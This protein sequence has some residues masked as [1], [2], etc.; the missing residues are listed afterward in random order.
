[1]AGRDSEM[2]KRQESMVLSQYTELYELII[3]K[4]NLLRRIMDLVDFSFV[5]EELREK[6]CPDNGRNAIDPVRL[7]KYLL[8]KSIY[9]LSDQDVVER[10]M[11][12]MSFKYFL[13]MAPEEPVI[14]PSTLTKFRKQR[15]KDVELLDM[16]IMKTMEI[17]L[18]KEVI[19]TRSIIVDATHTRA[20]YALKSPMEILKDQSK[21]LRKS[22]YAVDESMKDKFPEKNTTEELT[23]ELDYCHQLIE[24]IE[25]E[26]AL[27]N[28]PKVKERLNRLKEIVADDAEHLQASEDEDARVGHKSADHSFFG[29]KTH[30]AMTEER[31][32][33]AAVITTGEKS[34]GK[35][36][37]ELIEKSKAAGLKVDTVIGDAAYSEKGN[38]ELTKS[39]NI[40]LVS[41][42]NPSVTQGN[43][44]KE[45]EFE[46]NKDAGMY[47]CKA[48]HLAFR[49]ARQGKKN[50]QKNQVDTYYFDVEKCKVCPFREG[51]YKEGAKTKTY[52]VSVK[53]DIH[54][55]QMAFQETEEFRRKAKER[56]KI[57]AKND[58]LKNR[59]GLKVAEASGLFGME[60]QGATAIFSV[61]L[62]RIL[63]L[64]DA[65]KG[66]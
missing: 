19:T 51:C 57:E 15:L 39:Q 59:H 20:R 25:Q 14:N 49:K 28:V 50:A 64:L 3:P 37:P 18:E 66:Q 16:L 38:I 34:D 58:E 45:D 23:D 22:V 65:K 47:V 42:L 12:D 52:S 5:F 60:I 17:A 41:K 13:G 2:I 62:K 7:F 61:N 40:A 54:L 11:Y 33:T 6:Y 10:S 43:R 8:L 21:N 36:L 44:S 46:F 29:Y 1:M 48:G 32:I 24:V 63:K 53:S 4:D 35:Y 55:E 30:L 27:P 31:I 56:Y 9:D 26:R